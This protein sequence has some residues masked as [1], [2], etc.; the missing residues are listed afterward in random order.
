MI[1]VF[2]RWI[3][4][5][6][7]AIYCAQCRKFKGW[8]PGKLEVRPSQNIL[9]GISVQAWGYLQN[10]R[11]WTKQMEWEIEHNGGK[12]EDGETFAQKWEDAKAKMRGK[13][14]AYAV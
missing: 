4:D 11:E 10:G 9:G 1:H 13:G 5:N 14:G 6:V 3:H 2:H 7:G 8:M 12:Y